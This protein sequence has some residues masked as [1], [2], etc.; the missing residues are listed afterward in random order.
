MIVDMSQML[1]EHPRDGDARKPEAAVEDLE[2]VN[3]AAL[4]YMNDRREN[5]ERMIAE[6]RRF[7][8]QLLQLSRMELTTAEPREVH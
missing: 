2:K 1:E 7:H 6:A 3:D 8:G 5:I 4:D